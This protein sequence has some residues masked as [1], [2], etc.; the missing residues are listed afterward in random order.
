MVSE[1]GS[2]YATFNDI[3]NTPC[4]SMYLYMAGDFHRVILIRKVADLIKPRLFG[5]V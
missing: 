4:L 2:T 5:A 1:D 3:D